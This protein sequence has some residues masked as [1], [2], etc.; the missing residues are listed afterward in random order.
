[1]AI[2]FGSEMDIYSNNTSGTLIKDTWNDSSWSG[3]N[4][5]TGASFTASFTALQY[6]SGEMD[7]YDRGISD[8]AIYKD[9]WQSGGTSWSGWNS[10]AGNEAG[11]PTALQYSTEMDVFATNYANNT[12]KDTW[13]QLIT[14]GV[15]SRR[16]C[17]G[18][19]RSGIK[20]SS[21]AS[22]IA[23]H[24]V[25]RTSTFRFHIHYSFYKRV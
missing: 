19:S 8:S 15:G 2:H 25:K 23:T 6:G 11:D 9:T 7:V 17:S 14:V 20:L 10:L 3:W 1:V 4:S 16:C 18:S 22:A 13:H 12:D 5:L 24:Q 21:S